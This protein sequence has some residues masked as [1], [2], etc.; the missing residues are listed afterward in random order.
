MNK[1]EIN[2][3]RLYELLESI[4]KFI[5]RKV[6]LYALGGT[7]LTILKI[8]PSTIDIDVNIH[9]KGEYE[10]ICKIFEQIGFEEKS[11]IRWITQEGLA[12][13]LFHGSNILGT[14]LLNDALKKSKF[15]K[16]FGN[17]ELYTLSLEDIIISKLARG[18]NRDFGDIKRI[19]KKVNLKELIQRYKE[20]MENSIGSNYKQKLLDLIEIKF[21]EWKFKIDK[22]L[23]N[24]VKKWE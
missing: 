5:E 6:K 23:I 2:I 20:T 15:I 13:D 11:T 16:S 7:A 1:Q 4:E 3:K 9:S 10:Y 21:K 14:D 24:E 17:I 22:D 12:F 19:I 8:K 18:D